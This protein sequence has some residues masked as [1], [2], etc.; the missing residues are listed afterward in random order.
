M[1]HSMNN[2]FSDDFINGI[3]KVDRSILI[4]IFKARYFWY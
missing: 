3:T 1:S 4:D 2:Y